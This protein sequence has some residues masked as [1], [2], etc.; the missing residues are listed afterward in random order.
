MGI[1]SF[2]A[3]M[4]EKP[5]NSPGVAPRPRR[6][7]PPGG[8]VD[9]G[10]EPLPSRPRDLGRSAVGAERR[11]GAMR[12]GTGSLTRGSI[13]LLAALAVAALPTTSAAGDTIVVTTT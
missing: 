12:T 13:E 7:L 2:R 3:E 4:D 9:R 5:S 8:I 10:G 11:R 6:E 1:A